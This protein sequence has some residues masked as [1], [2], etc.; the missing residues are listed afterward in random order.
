MNMVVK[1][2]AVLVGLSEMTSPLPPVRWVR[3]ARVLRPP[4]RSRSSSP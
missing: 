1:E 3:T 2:Q 4:S